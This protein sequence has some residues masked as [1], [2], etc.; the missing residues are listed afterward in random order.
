MYN[1]D[2][3]ILDYI[4]KNSLSSSKEIFEG[5][6]LKIGY[7]TVKRILKRLNEQDYVDIIGK[8]RGTKYKVSLH[9][10]LPNQLTLKSISKR[11]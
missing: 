7:A 4:S 10:R 6:K 8:G 2:L 9:I 3:Q 11:R 5:S 1:N